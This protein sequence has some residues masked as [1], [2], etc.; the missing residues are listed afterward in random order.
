MGPFGAV[1]NGVQGVEWAGGLVEGIAAHAARANDPY[2]RLSVTGPGQD[3]PQ[4]QER[5]GDV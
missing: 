2:G 5:R 3:Q 4:P 1:R